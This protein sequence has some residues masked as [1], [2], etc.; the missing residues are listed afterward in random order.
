MLN[1][2]F[3]TAE[4]P[5]T[6]AA[7]GQAAKL[8]ACRN[9][10]QRH[11]LLLALLCKE[12][13]GNV[14]G[15]VVTGQ[16]SSGYSFSTVLGYSDSLKKLAPQYGP[17]ND[18]AAKIKGG[19]SD[20]FAANSDVILNELRRLGLADAKSTLTVPLGRARPINTPVTAVSA[21]TLVLH[22][23]SGAAFSTDELTYV[24]AWAE[25]E[26]EAARVQ[27]ANETA[28][29]SLL[30]FA[31]SFVQAAE[32]QDFSQLGH[33]ERVTSYALSL[34]RALKLSPEHLTDLYLAAMLHDIG[35]LGS[36]N[37]Q[38]LDEGHPQRGANMLAAAPLLLPATLGI[39]SHHERWDG[40]GYPDKL[41]GDRIPLLARII[42]VANTFDA[43]S[44]ERGD[45]LPMHAV[46]KTLRERAGSE[47]DP[48]LVEL[49]IN[50]L[51]QGKTTQEM[52]DVNE[53]SLA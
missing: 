34:G 23:H 16:Q 20:L 17:W 9:A 22:R 27:L 18:P 33:A 50:I 38:S 51:R 7:L 29:R 19:G 4:R 40:D 31:R 10:D 14:R 6:A 41:T 47:L 26:Q 5:H 32:A 43:L 25:L 46:E 28:R 52:R 37:W 11:P 12:L 39:R 48:D 42:A 2:L 1:R 36:N 3:G 13:G 35:K 15:Y 45:A 8:V 44:S 21:Q 24:L 53:S 30:E 49:L